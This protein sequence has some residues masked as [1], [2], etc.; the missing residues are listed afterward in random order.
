MS[1]LVDFVFLKITLFSLLF[2]FPALSLF[3]SD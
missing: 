1:T 3:R 2:R